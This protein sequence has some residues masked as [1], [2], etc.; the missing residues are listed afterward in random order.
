MNSPALF[1]GAAWGTAPARESSAWRVQV[2]RAGIPG[3]ERGRSAE[4]LGPAGKTGSGSGRSCHGFAEE[5]ALDRRGGKQVALDDRA[6]L[7]QLGLAFLAAQVH[8]ADGD[9]VSRVLRS[10]ERKPMVHGGSVLSLAHVV[11]LVL[12]RVQRPVAAIPDGDLEIG[13]GRLRG[14]I[15]GLA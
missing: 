7:E 3:G 9:D 1:T 8:V 12:E 13:V 10:H 4:Q 2:D 15:G 14:P 5:D 11:D 6:D